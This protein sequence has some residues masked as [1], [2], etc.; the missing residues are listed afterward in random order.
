MSMTFLDLQNE[1]KRRAVR[2]Q[3][4]TTYDT[5]T[6]N[7][8]NAS[9]FTINR[10]AAWRATRRKASITTVTTYDTGSGAVTVTN[11]SKNFTVTGATFLTD[12]IQIGRYI[13]F[14]GS[15]KYY[16]IASITG[17]TTGTINEVYDGTTTTTATYSILPQEEYILPIQSGHRMF[18]WHRE[19]GY[20]YQLIYVPDQ[21]FYEQGVQDTTTGV[22]TH[23]RMWGEDMVRQQLLEAS[24]I[25]VVSSS[26]SDTTQQVTIF[27]TVSGYPDYETINLNGTTNAVGTKSFTTVERIAKDASTTGRITVTGNSGN[28]TLAVLPVGDTTAGILY[29]KI[30]LYPLPDTVFDINIQYY[31]DVYRLVNDDDIHELGQEFDEAIICLSVSKIKYENSQKEGDK[32]YA[33]YRAELQ[34]LRALN[35]DKIDWFPSLQRPSVSRGQ[36]AFIHSNLMYSQLGGYFGPKS[37]G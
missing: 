6:K 19:E 12:A 10:A 7:A 2:D 22:P 26:A 21:T 1:V 31:K 32:W 28:C 15:S 37:R 18:M 20:P 14:S 36:N 16:K 27:G 33:M 9:L 23:Y 29:R 4:G 13:K 30:Q 3:S 25:T 24:V 11:D 35:A 8:I 17:E 5:A 34:S